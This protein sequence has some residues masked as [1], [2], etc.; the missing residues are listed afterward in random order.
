MYLSLF[1]ADE[2]RLSQFQNRLR[3]QRLAVPSMTLITS[4]KMTA[5]RAQKK[6]NLIRRRSSSMVV[7]KIKHSQSPQ[8]LKGERN[9]DSNSLAKGLH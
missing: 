3:V 9:L 8:R 7:R 5:L 4:L 1:W 6:R 2:E